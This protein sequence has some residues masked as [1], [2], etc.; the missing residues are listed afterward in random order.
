MEV[1]LMS[2]G[3]EDRDDAPEGVEGAES[4]AEAGNGSGGSLFKRITS[5]QP[6][7][8]AV[9]RLAF[10]GGGALVALFVAAFGARRWRRRG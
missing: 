6:Q 9:K 8:R 3:S 1:L 2:A 4:V 7:D 10:A 5:G